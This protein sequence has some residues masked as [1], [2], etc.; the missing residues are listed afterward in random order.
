MRGKRTPMRIRKEAVHSQHTSLCHRARKNLHIVL[1]MELK[2]L[3]S[4]KLLIRV[5]KLMLS[6]DVGGS[7][8]VVSWK[9]KS[10]R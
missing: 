5:N 10:R 7:D 1:L 6:E 8:V 3:M 2:L 9:K 4:V